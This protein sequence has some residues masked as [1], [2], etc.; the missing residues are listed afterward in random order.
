MADGPIPRVAVPRQ[1]LRGG[2]EAHL[3]PVDDLGG[4]SRSM[5]FWWFPWPFRSKSAG[6]A[7]GLV[8]IVGLTAA[9]PFL[10]SFR[11]PGSARREIE[12]A[13]VRRV[14]GLSV[15]ITAA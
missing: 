5:R 1:G 13:V 8:L 11:Q 4:G 10:A 14:D 12:T 7:T 15:T 3:P 6:F 9:G 2:P